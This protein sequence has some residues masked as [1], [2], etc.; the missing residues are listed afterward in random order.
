M[1]YQYITYYN[2]CVFTWFNLR[3]MIP[4]DFPSFY[5]YS[6]T[7][8]RY[9]VYKWETERGK[10][11]FNFSKLNPSRMY[12]D[13]LGGVSSTTWTRLGDAV[14]RREEMDPIAD[15]RPPEEHHPGEGASYHCLSPAPSTPR[16]VSVCLLSA[17]PADLLGLRHPFWQPLRQREAARHVLLD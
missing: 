7:E 14:D 8:Y 10:R 5:F 3:Y 15:P 13:E 6:V 12:W 2:W 11:S 4:K 16:T 9:F 17:S 1:V